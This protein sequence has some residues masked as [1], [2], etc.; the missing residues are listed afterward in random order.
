MV[1]PCLCRG[2]ACVS[3]RAGTS[4]IALLICREAVERERE[5]AVTGAPVGPYPR[6]RALR[7]LPRRRLRCTQLRSLAHGRTPHARAQ[8]RSHPVTLPLLG[9]PACILPVIAETQSYSFRICANRA[10]V[11]WVMRPCY[12]FVY[13]APVTPD[14]PCVTSRLMRS[15]PAVIPG[16]SGSDRMAAYWALEPRTDRFSP[17]PTVSRTDNGIPPSAPARAAGRPVTD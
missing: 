9:P 11:N 4:Q 13:Y 1:P 14:Q 12:A 6:C 8:K 16:P 10:D 2:Q 7:R 3:R 5:D 15:R 17:F